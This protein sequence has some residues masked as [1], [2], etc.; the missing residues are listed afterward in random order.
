M[1]DGKR[2]ARWVAIPATAM[3][4]VLGGLL[5]AV[6]GAGA[7]GVAA[8]AAPPVVVVAL[9]D[10][11]RMPIVSRLVVAMTVGLAIP[12]LTATALAASPIGLSRGTLGIALAIISGATMVA[13]LLLQLPGARRRGWPATGRTV[14]PEA[15]PSR[16][17]RSTTALAADEAPGA[18]TLPR[19]V[20]P[21]K[22]PRDRAGD[23]A[24]L[25]LALVVSVGAVALAAGTSPDP[26]AGP[27]L[28]LAQERATAPSGEP[29]VRAWE[30]GMDLR[31]AAEATGVASDGRTGR[32]TWPAFRLRDGGIWRGVLDREWLGA[33]RGIR[34]TVTCE[35]GE[36]EALVRQIEVRTELHADG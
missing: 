17:S 8:L 5:L 31:C 34:V 26:A 10:G 9:L 32:R 33:V 27:A 11:R 35:D 25:G 19:S 3:V 36:G 15:D 30:A 13:W 6:G 20:R 18:G 29:V 14:T 12:T 22:R 4:G 28:L 23:V 16:R 21:H 2:V 1:P 7:A 24:L